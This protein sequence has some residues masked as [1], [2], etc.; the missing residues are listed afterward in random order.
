MAKPPSPDSGH[1]IPGNIQG[2]AVILLGVLSVIEAMVAATHPG[3]PQKS[4]IAFDQIDRV[5]LHGAWRPSNAMHSANMIIDRITLL[6]RKPN[7]AVPRRPSPRCSAPNR[8]Y[9]FSP[10]SAYLYQ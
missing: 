6:Q 1:G 9:E 5:L 7:S 3:N 4:A 2:L 10:S 8:A